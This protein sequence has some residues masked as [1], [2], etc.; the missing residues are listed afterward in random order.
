[1][2]LPREFKVNPQRAK[3]I[4]DEVINSLISTKELNEAIEWLDSVFEGEE[5]LFAFFMLGEF[6]I[7]SGIIANPAEVIQACM[8]YNAK[9]S[10]KLKNYTK[11]QRDR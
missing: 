9:L 7:L 4:E 3:E 1:M 2:V 11:L 10:S 6:N 5:K 8:A